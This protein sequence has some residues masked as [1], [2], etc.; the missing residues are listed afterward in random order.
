MLDFK[1]LV[2]SIVM[3]LG[4]TAVPAVS[5]AY[6]SSSSRFSSLLTGIFKY[7]SILSIAGGLLLSLL[8]R[9]LLGIFYAASN[10]DIV[11]NGGELLFYMGISVLPCAVATTTVYTV[12]ALGFAKSAIPAF[13]VSGVLRVMLNFAIITDDSINI[14]GAVISNCAG[15][16][17]IVIMNFVTIRK[18]KQCENFF[19]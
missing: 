13:I 11:K 6:E 17:V 18:K 8:S 9:E 7:S 16:A 15:F 10:E 3:V 2:P 14:K 1:N 12:Q 5:T 19:F 4:I